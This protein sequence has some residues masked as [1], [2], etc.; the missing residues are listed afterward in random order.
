MIQQ[1]ALRTAIVIT[2]FNQS[3]YT[4]RAIESLCRTTPNTDRFCFDYALF[5]DCSTDDTSAVVDSFRNQ[6]VAYWR[7]PCNSG[8]TYLWNEAYRQ[9]AGHDYL[10]IVNN[11]VVFTPNWCAIILD[12]LVAHRCVL[13]GPVTNG[14]GHVP[15]QD[16]RNFISDYTPSDAWEDL[17]AT[18]RKL[19]G[20]Q[21]FAVDL[22]NGF[23]M[24]FDLKLLEEAQ[25]YRSSEPFDPQN[26]NFGNE[27]EIQTRLKPRPLVV[28]ESFVFHY[29]RVSIT[30]GGG[31]FVCYRPSNVD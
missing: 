22:I 23:C 4:R 31:T 17:L 19:D 1:I 8:V 16:V 11:D 30:D 18:R 5:D 21:P 15:H 24:V 3:P 29:K 6:R 7:S 27:D 13:G 14:P 25:K 10:A 9:Y 12:A 26:R 20:R 28:P 2:A